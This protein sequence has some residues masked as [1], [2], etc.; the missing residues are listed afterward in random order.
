MRDIELLY[1][2]AAIVA[3]IPMD[4]FL[5]KFVGCASNTLLGLWYTF[6]AG[7]RWD[8]Y[9]DESNVFSWHFL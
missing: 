7:D 5:M 3:R 4:Y 1:D 6:G 9:Q 2:N 8:F